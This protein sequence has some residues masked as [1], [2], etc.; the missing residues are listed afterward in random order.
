MKDNQAEKRSG[1]EQA[2]QSNHILRAVNRFSVGTFHYKVEG[3]SEENENNFK[4]VQYVPIYPQ[5]Y[6]QKDCISGAEHKIKV[7]CD[8]VFIG[9]YK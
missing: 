1:R 6:T 3:N 9:S 4:E 8:K 2:D 5:L 7:E